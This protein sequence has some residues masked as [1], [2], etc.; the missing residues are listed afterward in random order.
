[1]DEKYCFV[2]FYYKP[3]GARFCSKCGNKFEKIECNMKEEKDKLVKEI[4]LVLKDD[5]FDEA[6]KEKWK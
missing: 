4:D 6:E 5:L 3:I 2:C 1:M